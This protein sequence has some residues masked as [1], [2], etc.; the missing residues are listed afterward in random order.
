[1]R[2]A[3]AERLGLT[4]LLVH[5]MRIE[6]TGLPGVEDNIRLRDGA[7]CRFTSSAR[8]VTFKIPFFNHTSAES[9]CIFYRSN[10]YLYIKQCLGRRIW[11]IANRNNGTGANLSARLQRLL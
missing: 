11:P 1:M 8:L 10:I 9:V 4:P 7:P 5:V 3:V 6:I 2:H